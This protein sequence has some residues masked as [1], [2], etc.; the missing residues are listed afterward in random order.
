MPVI[1]TVDMKAEE[2]LICGQCGHEIVESETAFLDLDSMR[3]S[4]KKIYCDICRGEAYPLW[5]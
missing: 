3:E 2:K 5:L 4:P 1:I